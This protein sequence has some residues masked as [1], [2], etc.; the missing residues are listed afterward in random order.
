MTDPAAPAAQGAVEC[1]EL[2]IIGTGI[3]GLNALFVAAQYCHPRSRIVVIDRNGSPGGMWTTA[4]DHARL[5]QPH[6]HFTVGNMAWNWTRPSDYLATARE[7]EAHLASCYR[8]LRERLNVAERFGHNVAR[9]HEVETPAGAFVQVEYHANERPGQRRLLRARRVIRAIGFDVPAI[10][11]LA[12]SSA[13]VRSSVPQDLAREGALDETAPVYI[14][15]GGKTALDT[16]HALLSRM[17]GRRVTIVKGDGMLF[18]DRDQLAPR[19]VRRWWQG[20]PLGAT[21]CAMAL[22]FDG[23]NEDSVFDRLRRSVG[24]GLGGAEEGF[25]FGMLSRAER[26]FVARGLDGQIDDY[27]DDVRDG[28]ETPELHLRRG[29]RVPVARGSIFVNCTG[30][31]LRGSHRYAP[32]V[33]AAGAILSVGPRSM[34][35]F[36]SSMSAF[37]LAHLFLSGRLAEA[38]LYELDAEALRRLNGRAYH[39]AAATL[40]VLNLLLAARVLRA[41]AWRNC[42]IDLD[43]HF[44]LPRRLPFM[45][46]LLRHAG[47]Y[48]AHCQ[49]A[50]DRVRLAYGVRCG[51]LERLQPAPIA[52]EPRRPPLKAP[53][54]RLPIGRTM[55]AHDA[56]LQSA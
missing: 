21:L 5:H 12:L 14:V 26:D 36:Q 33:S 13:Q 50:L 1:C 54:P 51:P 10:E 11:P 34:V 44:P 29:G 43:R 37:L 15:G 55:P 45:L 16:A 46:H 39:C 56:L 48:A 35:H 53:L 40:S 4:Y 22:H 2:C 31:L 25:L 47:E 24:I 28:P 38:G 30:H 8:T 3:A 27:L 23:K 18:A 41:S 7:V 42:L 52:I 49:W 9:C 6:P 32:Y 17:P 19:G 20:R